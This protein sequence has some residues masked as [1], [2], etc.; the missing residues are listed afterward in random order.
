M[1]DALR[2]TPDLVY[3]GEIRKPDEIKTVLDFAETGHYIV[4]TMHASS[5]NETMQRILN[6]CEANS[7]SERAATAKRIIA[8]IHMEPLNDNFKLDDKT[9]SIP[10]IWLSK[11]GGVENLVANGLSSI[12]VNYHRRK[13][14]GFTNLDERLT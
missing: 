1:S 8:I 5:V 14:R 11:N 10:A 9:V 6:A 4:S 3:V 13:Q 7:P 12:V 2:Q